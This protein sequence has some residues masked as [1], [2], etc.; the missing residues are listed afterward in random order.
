MR[1][2]TSMHARMTCVV[3]NHSASPPETPCRGRRTQGGARAGRRNT[4]RPIRQVRYDVQGPITD[5]LNW[6]Q[7]RL[8]WQ[9][10]LGPPCGSIPCVRVRLPRPARRSTAAV[11][12]GHHRGAWVLLAGSLA[13]GGSR[14]GGDGLCGGRPGRDCVVERPR[15]GRD[16]AARKREQ[17]WIELGRGSLGEAAKSPIRQSC[18]AVFCRQSS[19]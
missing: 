14:V 5:L 6:R 19:P 10:A 8:V 2:S 12:A 16:P 4:R 9:D 13:A 15:G 7:A 11:C 18:R 17:D 3:H 1:R